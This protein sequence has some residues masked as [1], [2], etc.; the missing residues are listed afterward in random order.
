MK[1]YLSKINESW[2]VDRL[3]TEWYQFNPSISTESIRSADIIWVIAPWMWKKIPKRHLKNKKVICTYYHIDFNKFGEYERNNFFELDQYVDEYHAAS[4]KTKEQLAKLTN[5]K[6]NTIPTWV[7]QKIWFEIKDKT[8]IRKNFNFEPN[9]FLVGSFQRDT[10]GHDLISPK[11]IKGPDIFVN[12]I[13]FLY[14]NNKNL[15]V[16]L[17]GTRRNYVIRKLNEMSIPFVYFEMAS[18]ETMNKLYNILDLYLVTSRVEGG[19]QAIMECALTKTPILSTNVGI[20]SEILHK[21]SI[22]KVSEFKEAKVNTEYSF[23]RV[24]N[25]IIPNG[26]EN[27]IKLLKRIYEKN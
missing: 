13:S 19:P 1:I 8:E 25:Y 15:K 11:L 23:Q 5:K 7:N 22:F 16:V 14:E 18:L 6:I 20:A 2:I 24:Q 4:S 12:L 9:E 17:S 27:F 26:F 10:E 3:R 21:N